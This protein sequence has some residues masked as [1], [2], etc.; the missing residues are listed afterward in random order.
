M[1]SIRN[2]CI[3]FVL[4]IIV[5][6]IAINFAIVTVPVGS[7]GVQ[8]KKFAIFGEK[9]VVAEDFQPGWHMRI[10]GLQNWQMFDSTVQTL[11]MTKSPNDGSRRGR[12]DVRVKS[13]DG[14]EV[15]IDV[16]L[17]YRI[18]DGTANELYQNTGSGVKYKQIVRDKTRKACQTILGQMQTEEF[19]NPEARR[20]ATTAIVENLQESL[21]ENF[22]S[23][24][25]VL[26]KN[27]QFDPQYE[28]KIQAK[29]LADQ[30]VQLNISLEKA[31][32]MRGLTRDIKKETEMK[33][34]V[35]NA[36]RKAEIVK[37]KNETA[38]R[39]ATISAKYN[40]ISTETKADA[41]LY[42][43]ENGAEGKLLIK[44]AEAEGEKLRNSAMQ[45]VGGS[46]IVALEAARNLNI[47]NIT[48]SSIDTDL[49]DIDAMASK[50]GANK[51]AE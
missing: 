17:K 38:I 9:G 13:S 22:V 16:T 39:L 10:A 8:T 51:T 50:L 28:K 37:I 32:K 14:Y 20:K 44:K 2:L 43:A 49:L 26:L 41:D 3:L 35:I 6:F 34:A 40:K 1:K 31:E 7:V 33:V 47:S 45:G 36:E 24:I 42:A 25:D 48:I 27:V 4:F 46:T 12:D 19:Y 29:K 23:I 5:A 21:N 30:E 15:S 11:E 18:K